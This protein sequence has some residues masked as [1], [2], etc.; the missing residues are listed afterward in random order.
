VVA[1]W[2][3]LLLGRV[4]YA[5][6]GYTLR[7]A[8][9]SAVRADAIGI[10]V[11]T[12]RWL[13]FSM[14]GAAAGLA[15]GLFAFSKGSID[16]TLISI[17]MSVDMLIMILAGGIQTLTGPLAGALFF[18]SIKDTF[19]PLTDFWRLLL[20]LAI[21]VVVLAFPRGIIG[22]LARLRERL[23]PPPSDRSSAA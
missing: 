17:P 4:I 23:D 6:F 10:D 5:P 21:I 20:G 16:P 22:G 18:H 14:A 19:M 2:A 7:A 11:K 8:R 12:P 13:A 1:G 9:D 15:G 3:I